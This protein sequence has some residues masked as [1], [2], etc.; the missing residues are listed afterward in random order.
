MVA[1]RCMGDMPYCYVFVAAAELHRCF[2]VYRR[3]GTAGLF[4][5]YHTKGT[6]VFTFYA[7]GFQST[8][9]GYSGNRRI[10]KSYRCYSVIVCIMRCGQY[11][12]YKQETA[13]S[14]GVRN[15]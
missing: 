7:D 1:V 9:D 13:L 14:M 2:P 3:D 12:G 8:F 15:V 4:V 6:V 5:E 11:S 10:Y